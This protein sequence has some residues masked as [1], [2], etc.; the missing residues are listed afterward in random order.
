MF[1][2]PHS[3]AIRVWHWT[4]FAVVTATLVTVLLASTMFKTRN[5]IGLVQDQLQKKG[6]TVST[7]QAQ[8]V[9]HE[10]NDQLW[11][12]HRII[13]YVICGLL[14]CRLVIEF[15]QPSEEKLGVKL[16]R[17]M[18]FRP[19]STSDISQ[20]Q[21]YVRVKATYLVFYGLILVMALT[22][23]G[24]AFEDNS[25][26]KEWHIP[27]KKLHSLVQ[28]FIY[29]FILLHLVGVIRADATRHK[30]LVSGMIHGKKQL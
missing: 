12:L 27:I 23:L 21:H 14:L 29:G 16:K 26:L 2:E 28:Y 10:F 13:G 25:L 3:L 17:A 7:S 20:K 8:A 24:L 18:G 5:T 22:G 9:S 30:G 19:E 6:V 4:F 1:N 15:A 11:N